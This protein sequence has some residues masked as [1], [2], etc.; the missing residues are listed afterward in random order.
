MRGVHLEK[1][2]QIYLNRTSWLLHHGQCIRQYYSK[3]CN[4]NAVWSS[5]HY[6]KLDVQMY[7]KY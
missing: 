1:K 4:I 3:H 7:L 2:A 6:K 5:L